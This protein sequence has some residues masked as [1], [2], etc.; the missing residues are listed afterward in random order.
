MNDSSRV[1]PAFREWFLV[2]FLFLLLRLGGLLLFHPLYNDMC[3][4]EEYYRGAMAQILLSGSSMP[5]WQ[6]RADNFGGGSLIEGILAAL[7]FKFLG[8]SAF[9]LRS[10][11]VMISLSALLLWFRILYREFSKKCAW[12]FALFFIFAPS[13]FQSYS[14]V[15]LGDHYETMLFSVLAL[16]LFLAI[17]TRPRSLLKIF[18]L[19]FLCA[20]GIWFDY[21]FSLT[22]G[23]LFVVWFLKD[24]KFLLDFRSWLFIP[25][26]LAGFSPWIYLNLQ[27]HFQGM[28]IRGVPLFHHIQPIKTLAYWRH[29]SWANSFLNDLWLAFSHPDIG[30]KTAPFPVRRLYALLLIL[31]AVALFCLRWAQK[32]GKPQPS[33]ESQKPFST[34][35]LYFIVYALFHLTAVE[36]TRFE[37]ERFI[38]PFM[39]VIFFAWARIMESLESITPEIRKASRMFFALPLLIL[40]L[41]LWFSMMSP[42]YTG[43]LLKN[44]GYAYD[45]LSDTPSCYDETSDCIK[46][47]RDLSKKIP[48]NALKGLWVS[49]ASKISNADETADPVEALKK[50]GITDPEF[51]AIFYFHFGKALFYTQDFNLQK[52]LSLL[53]SHVD[54]E[55]P[56]G[57]IC[58]LGI[59]RGLGGEGLAD[60]RLIPGNIPKGYSPEYFRERGKRCARLW[61]QTHRT[62]LEISDTVSS[63]FPVPQR[64][65]ERA[66]FLQGVGT[67]MIRRTYE[68]PISGQRLWDKVLL[69]FSPS[70][71]QSFFQGVGRVYEISAH[72]WRAPC[73]FWSHQIIP[74]NENPLVLGWINEGRQEIASMLDEFYKQSAASASNI[75]PASEMTSKLKKP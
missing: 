50:T 32:K 34:V 57:K 39:P 40:G 20:F 1:R 41:C 42:V 45:N 56:I 25:G 61:Y 13:F 27:N 68:K 5:Y 16:Q 60:I 64:A 19:G 73:R 7:F 48:P 21:L 52:A 75:S 55:S 58:S 44:P 29:Y 66:A 38:M 17:Q 36:L 53:A 37:G 69:R 18:L 70:D 43:F 22:V 6:Y 31:P 71:Q 51:A 33:Q 12:Y 74:T 30:F 67:I 15:P 49:L 10:L 14:M 72:F 3:P 59:F 24:R 8:D 2:I 63:V 28:M 54:L 46:V 26:F 62:F 35:S 65:K 9:V 23:A 4:R 47:H 11:S